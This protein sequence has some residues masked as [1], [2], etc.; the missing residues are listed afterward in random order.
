M[1]FFVIFFSLYQF[2]SLFLEASRGNWKDVESLA[3]KLSDV[4]I[5]NEAGV[6]I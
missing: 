2:S 3:D 6:S 5:K 4:N 1:T